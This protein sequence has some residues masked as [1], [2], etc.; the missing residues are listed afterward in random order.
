MTIAWFLIVDSKGGLHDGGALRYFNLSRELIAAGH[1]VYYI[2]AR[3]PAESERLQEYLTPFVNDGFLTGYFE[4]DFPPY[5]R[6]RG[7]L[8]RLTLLPSARSWVLRA[9]Q[10][11]FKREVFGRVREIGADVCLVSHRYFLCLFPEIVRCAP[12]VFDWVDSFVLYHARCLRTW[13]RQ[14]RLSR[15][16]AEAK[17]LVDAILDECSYGRSTS[18]NLLASPVDKRCFD[19]LTLRPDRNRVLMNGAR[20]APKPSAAPKVAGRLVFAGRM[21]FLPNSQAAL[22]FID[23][24]MPLIVRERPDAHLVVVGRCPQPELLKRAGHGVVVTGYVPDL[25]GEVARSQLFVAPMIS[26]SG[27]KNKVIEALLAGTFVIGTNIALEFLDPELRALLEVADTPRQLAD[28]ILEFLAAPESYE[29]RLER[30]RQRVESEFGWGKRAGELAAILNEF[31]SGAR[32]DAAA[33][34]DGLIR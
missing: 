21:D 27:F 28:R 9:S 31:A 22:W 25:A 34:P 3:D 20:L 24:V 16:P 19:W 12:A 32:Q 11:A 33:R 2:L 6:W 13:L 17:R 4:V 18:A 1:R 23:N 14:R 29:E 8:S 30:A 15:I 5:P 10:R 7:K 26:G